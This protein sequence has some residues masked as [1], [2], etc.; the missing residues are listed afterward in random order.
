MHYNLE[1][2]VDRYLSIYH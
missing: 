2:R 1:V